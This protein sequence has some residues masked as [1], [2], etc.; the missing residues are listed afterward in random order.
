MIIALKYHELIK[1]DLFKELSNLHSLLSDTL[2][3]DLTFQLR[4]LGQYDINEW[5]KINEKEAFLTISVAKK[6]INFIE[7]E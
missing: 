3:L 5:E 2:G 6:L 1:G 7:N 4:K